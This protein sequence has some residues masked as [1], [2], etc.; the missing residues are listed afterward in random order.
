MRLD[1]LTWVLC[2]WGSD[3]QDN[4][5]AEATRLGMRAAKIAEKALGADHPTTKQYIENWC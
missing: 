3:M 4:D 5:S 1:V 2:N